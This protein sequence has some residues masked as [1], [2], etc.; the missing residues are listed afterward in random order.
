M[1]CFFSLHLE[2]QSK[3]ESAISWAQENPIALECEAIFVMNAWPFTRITAA[4]PIPYKFVFYFAL[5][6][7]FRFSF[8]EHNF[9]SCIFFSVCLFQCK[10][11]LHRATFSDQYEYFITNFSHTHSSSKFIVLFLCLLKNFAYISRGE[12]NNFVNVQ[13]NMHRNFMVWPNISS[14]FNHLSSETKYMLIGFFYSYFSVV[15]RWLLHCVN[16]KHMLL[17]LPF[18]LECFCLSIFGVKKMPHKCLLVFFILTDWCVCN[19]NWIQRLICSTTD[20]H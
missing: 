9:S 7:R 11:A 2:I 20:Y 17:C 6:S 13:R 8:G 15:E 12:P 14:T 1:E 4:P 5:F 16:R 19:N 10:R 18:G 3:V